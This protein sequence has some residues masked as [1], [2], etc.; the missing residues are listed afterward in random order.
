MFLKIFID[1]RSDLVWEGEVN[2]AGKEKEGMEARM[3]IDGLA[4]PSRW[5]YESLVVHLY[6]SSGTRT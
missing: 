6:I 3:Q 5:G 1:D 4:S 2:D